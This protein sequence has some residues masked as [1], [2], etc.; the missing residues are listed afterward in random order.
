MAL[1]LFMTS[2]KSY[3]IHLIVLI[4]L[5]PPLPPSP[6]PWG[7]MRMIASLTIEKPQARG[8]ALVGVFPSLAEG[9]GE[10]YYLYCD[11]SLKR[12]AVPPELKGAD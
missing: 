8:Q 2:Q 10:L 9:R 6:P 1:V 3:G 5:P 11:G 4:W 12:H 7:P